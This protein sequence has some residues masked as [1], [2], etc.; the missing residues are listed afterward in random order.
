MILVFLC[1]YVCKCSY[2]L[3]C[4]CVILVFLCSYVL[5]FLFAPTQAFS[6]AAGASVVPML[7]VVKQDELH[8]KSANK[9]L[10]IC[11]CICITFVFFCLHMVSS[12]YCASYWSYVLLLVLMTHPLMHTGEMFGCSHSRGGQLF[13]GVQQWVDS[14]K[15]AR[16]CLEVPEEIRSAKYLMVLRA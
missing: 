16:G 2:V 6:A 14:Y 8:W 13:E 3:F 4:L 15:A 1:S 10:Y 9:V 7:A 12:E 11:I 5:M